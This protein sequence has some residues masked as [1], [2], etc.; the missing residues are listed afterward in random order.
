[1]ISYILLKIKINDTCYSTVRT[2]LL[3]I[4]TTGIGIIAMGFCSWGEEIGLYSG[5]SMSKWEFMAKELCGSQGKENFQEEISGAMG[6][7]ETNLTGF[8]LII[9]QG[10]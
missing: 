2:T 3:R 9:G 8:L 1:M 4:Y 6:I 5:Y 7:L 10:D